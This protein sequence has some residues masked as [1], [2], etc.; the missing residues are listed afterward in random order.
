MDRD[1]SLKYCLDRKSL[2]TSGL[3]NFTLGVTCY[4]LDIFGPG[5]GLGHGHEAAVGQDGAH[6]EQTEQRDALIKEH[7][8]MAVLSFEYVIRNACSPGTMTLVK[9]TSH[10]FSLLIVY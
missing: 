9:L 1:S 7:N 5:G 8:K 10:T 3:W 6:D 4:S 2:R